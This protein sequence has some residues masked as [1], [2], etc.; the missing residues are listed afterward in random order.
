VVCLGCTV[1][2]LPVLKTAI[3][4]VVHYLLVYGVRGE[5]GWIL[6]KGQTGSGGG[7]GQQPSN[8]RAVNQQIKGLNQWSFINQE[9]IIK[10]YVPSAI[11]CKDRVTD[12][13]VLGPLKQENIIVKY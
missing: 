10:F 4:D 13:T 9:K 12:F 5:I 1:L 11:S 3:I 8:A 2:H 7:V 6:K